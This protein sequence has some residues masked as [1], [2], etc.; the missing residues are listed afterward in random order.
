MQR[1]AQS[2]ESKI[3]LVVIDG[4]GGLP[5]SGKTALEMAKTPHLDALTAEGSSGLIT[6][7]SPGVTPGSGP[8]HLALF[9]YDPIEFETGRGVLAA[10][11]CGFDL[12]PGD[13]AARIN[14]CTIENG[15]VTDRRAGRIP[16]ELCEKLC[17]KL[18]EKIHTI[19]D[20]QIFI[21]PVKQYRAMLVM[22]G[23]GLSRTIPDTD[24]QAIGKP[25]IEPQGEDKTSGIVRKFL[26]KAKDI[27]QD[28]H[29]ANMILLRGFSSYEP[30]PQMQ[31]LYGLKAGAIAAYPAYKGVS[32]LVGMDIL[33]TGSEWAEEIATLKQQYANYDYLYIHFKETDS[34]GEDGD[35]NMKANLI[36]KFDSLLP[37]IR[38]LQPD[39]LVVTGDH[40]TPAKMKGHSWH[41]IPIVLHAAH[42]RPDAVQEFT[43]QSCLAGA[44][45]QIRSTDLMP[46]MLAHAGK[47]RKFGA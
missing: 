16:T 14:F 21:K 22:R 30:F 5:I 2:T 35:I 23:P 12:Q 45:G 24:P 38:E 1:L 43:E 33:D 4:I 7:I 39:V 37:R 42:A 41:P 29:P 36:E 17:R 27:L 25:P 28:E 13:M 47:L 20:I 15:K 31:E 9:G 18:Q 19:D 6:P 44:I 11:G 10:L 34:A 8:A 46:L 40:C 32:R 26:G 3:I